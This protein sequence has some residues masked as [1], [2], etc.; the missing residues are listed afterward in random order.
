MKIVRVALCLILPGVFIGLVH[1]SK[2][3]FVD[4]QVQDASNYSI[5][6]QI[7]SVSKLQC[8][9]KCKMTKGTCS[10]VVFQQSGEGYCLLLGVLDSNPATNIGGVVGVLDRL[11]VSENSSHLSLANLPVDEGLKSKIYRSGEFVFINNNF[12]S[13][14]TIELFKC[15]NTTKI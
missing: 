15:R 2:G 5:I 13:V 14:I 6:R 11:R 9:L 4:T 12:Y 10:N 1:G 7:E 8:L 3:F